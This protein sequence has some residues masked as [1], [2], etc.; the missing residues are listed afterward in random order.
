MYPERRPT[1]T[2]ITFL[3]CKE[4]SLALYNVGCFSF[5]FLNEFHHHT[6][7][8]RLHL[9]KRWFWFLSI[10]FKCLR[11][12]WLLFCNP[13]PPETREHKCLLKELC[14]SLQWR[15]QSVLKAFVLL[16]QN[17]ESRVSACVLTWV[18]FCIPKVSLNIIDSLVFW[19]T[20]LQRKKT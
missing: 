10:V 16:C 19:F 17:V 18:L 12:T 5:H 9:R 15:G 13:V 20:L 11:L 4:I 2:F 14:S 1:Q 3:S 6:S 7:R 8:T